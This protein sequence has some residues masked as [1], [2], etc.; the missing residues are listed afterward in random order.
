MSSSAQRLSLDDIRKDPE[1][2]R[3]LLSHAYRGIRIQVLLRV[4]LV[5][6][7]ALTVIIVPPAHY[8]AWCY[9]TVV[10]YAI[11]V[12][13]V[14]R[15]SQQ[16]GERPVQ[17]VWLALFVDVLA[18]AALTV[19]A[20]LSDQESW[21]ADILLNG[22]FLVPMLATTQL[23]PGVGTAVTVPT[24]LVY[25]LS[26]IAAR[27]ANGEPWASVLLRTGILAA[28]SL[29]CVLLS[30]MQRSRVLTIAG[31]VSDRTQLV[32]ELVNVEAQARRDLAEE[33]HDGALQYVLAA[34]QD[35]DDVRQR[36]D[37]ESL[38]RVAYA[39]K[40]SSALLRSKVS[41]LHPAVLE[42]SGLRGAIEELVRTTA[43]RS[44]LS[45]S[46]EA[47]GWDDTWRTSADDLVYSAARELLA[48]AVKHA[49]ARALQVKLSRR[50]GTIFLTVADDGIGI[51]EGELERQLSKGHIGVASQRVRVE[52]AGG[53]FDLEP[54]APGT[55]EPGT[56]ATVGLP[57]ID[58]ASS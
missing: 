9:V 14:T 1:L 56:I 42:Q 32:R 57:A 51:A 40:E 4:L 41:Q 34:R 7:M 36:G 29:G 2:L 44:G 49:Q 5:V 30:A 21:T 31:L 26:S 18:L 38:D 52:A 17:L 58:L 45:V 50:D 15:W 16:G 12:G 43:A 55:I 8:R 19:L 10:V 22:F 3:I 54:A 13:G 37:A 11:W 53:Q 24:V 28:L 48:N 27:H 25:L 39:L 20:S 46:L 35:L 33:L 47:E 23:R 6:F